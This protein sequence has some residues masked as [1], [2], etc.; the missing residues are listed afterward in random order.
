[1]TPTIPEDIICGIVDVLSTT[2]LPSCSLVSRVFRAL[3][4]RRLFHSVYLNTRR[5]EHNSRLH[6]ILLENPIL[7]SFIQALDICVMAD[8]H[9]LPLKAVCGILHLVRTHVQELWIDGEFPYVAEPWNS[10]PESLQAA[11]LSVLSH[12]SCVH[13]ELGHVGLPITH[14]SESSHLRHLRLTASG[15][16]S[17]PSEGVSHS[18]NAEPQIQGYLESLLVTSPVT[19][20]RILQTLHNPLH[21]CPLSLS[22]LKVFKIRFT[23]S[24][25]PLIQSILDL[26]ADHLQEI[27]LYKIS[28]FLDFARLTQLRTLV[29]KFSCTQAPGVPL[30]VCAIRMI[31]TVPAGTVELGFTINNRHPLLVIM[32]SEWRE[33][34]GLLSRERHAALRRVTFYGFKCEEEYL[35]DCFKDKLPRLAEKGV[36]SVG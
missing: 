13:V 21:P 28:G 22:R 19:A 5:H 15:S 24:A 9:G 14:L 3:C 8:S 23:E 2:D 29:L 12:P 20:E 33:I 27:A 25:S 10:L 16:V 32:D 31:E 34:D 36:L 30:G 1:M 4:Q 18:G 11:L 17:I 7:A 26:A 35:V 6:L